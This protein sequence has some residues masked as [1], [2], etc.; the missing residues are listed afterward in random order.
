[1]LLNLLHWFK[2][3]KY[4]LDF[5]LESNFQLNYVR[6]VSESFKK[7]IRFTIINPQNPQPGYKLY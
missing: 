1:M 5:L 6:V 3:A 7:K 4:Q 2:L